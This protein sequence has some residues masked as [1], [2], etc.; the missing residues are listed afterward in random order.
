MQQALVAL[1]AVIAAPVGTALYIIAA[2]A[3][4]S[5]LP[6]H[7]RSRIQP[8]LWLAPGLALLLAFLVYPSAHTLVLSFFNADS[9]RPVGL[10]NYVFI[11]TDQTISSRPAIKRTI[12][13][14]RP[15]FTFE[16][17]AV[18]DE[19]TRGRAEDVASFQVKKYAR[20]RRTQA[21]KACVLRG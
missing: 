16:S 19:G 5:R 11:A 4:A 15:S 17:R 12:Q 8:W 1:L 21:A 6:G 3:A 9:T 18:P 2:E 10:D 20:I 7:W 14:M 13:A